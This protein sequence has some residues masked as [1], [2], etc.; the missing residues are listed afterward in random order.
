MERIFDRECLLRALESKYEFT[1]VWGAY[2]IMRLE[3]DRIKDYLPLFLKSPFLDIQDAGVARIAEIGAE[4]YVAEIL[5]IFR[6]S[7]GQIKYSAAFAM[8]QFPNDFTKSLI[9]KW[10]EQLSVSDQS[11]RMEF[12]AATFAY[13][14]LDQ[15][16]NFSKVMEALKASQHDAIKSSVLFVNLLMFCETKSDFHSILDQ[17]FILRDLN[18]D[19]ELT[20]QLIDYFGQF[21]LKE[22]WAENLS[23]GYSI[24]SVYEQCYILLDFQDNIADRRF[25]QEIEQS[26]GD[27]DRLH[28]GAPENHEVFL[29]CV[30]RW[31]EHLSKDSDVDSRLKWVVQG[32]ARNQQ[33][34]LRTIPK[35]LELECHFLL[36]LPLLIILEKSLSNWLAN[37]AEHVENI[38]NYY[39]SSL[40]TK[41]HREEILETFFSEAPNWSHEQLKIKHTHS[42]L[43]P[44]DSRHEILW[45]FYRSQLLGYDIPWPSIFPNPDYSLHLAE[46][47]SRI[48][49]TNFLYY[50]QKQD[51]VAIDYALQLFQLKPQRKTIDLVL[52][53]FDYLIHNHTEILYQT[54]EYLPNPAFIDLLLEKYQH[55]E[56]EIARLIFII[57]EIFNLPIPDDIEKDMNVLYDTNFQNSGIKKPVRL[58]CDVCNNTFQYTVNEIYVDEGSILRMNKLAQDSVWVSQGFFCKKCSSPI[59][60]L[61]DD[62]QLNEFSLQSR[63]DRILNITAQPKRNHFGQKIILMDFPRYNGITYSP[64]AFGALVS[65]C[66][67]NPKVDPDEIQML[68]MKQ[69]KMHKAMRNWKF[70]K[71]VL[72]KIEP[73]EKNRE[74]WTFLMGLSN[75][76]LS[77][78]ADSRKYFDWI[79]KKYSD[80]STSSSHVPFV[81]QSKYFLK[82]LDS[83]VSKRARFKVITGKK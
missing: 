69:A 62:S 7:E 49:F 75:Y 27:Y 14:Q 8:S 24:S 66:E 51:R 54:I 53:H 32:F 35:I 31:I 70:C 20:F 59:P 34:F 38:A 13:L 4:E 57:C 23:R 2:Q 64:A 16:R 21:E 45:S 37:P 6:E 3:N 11:T 42:P 48:Y 71:D 56:Y 76:K 83:N 30:C 74:E 36:T 65:E 60:F 5:K 81:E 12:E 67:K 17:Y 15:R 29:K 55:E 77:R 63:V 9:Q 82:A 72:D 44:E 79:V 80:S 22:W 43:K 41:E 40:L 78:F 1:A 52:E 10:F 19:A 73:L 28:P 50:I 58:H 68:R 25:W 26:Y 39:H 61:L 33:Y 18:S 46:G 47:L